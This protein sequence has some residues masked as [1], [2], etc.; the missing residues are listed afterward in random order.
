MTKRSKT[1]LKGYFETG[2]VPNQANYHD[3]IESQLNL[4]DTCFKNKIKSFINLG[5]SCIYPKK[6]KQPIKEEY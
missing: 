4:V 1:T 2:D 3:L 5:S 6:A